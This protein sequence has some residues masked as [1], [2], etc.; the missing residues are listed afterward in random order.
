MRKITY[1]TFFLLNVTLCFSQKQFTLNSFI[2]PMN[3]MVNGIR[4]KVDSVGIKIRTNY[5]KFDVFTFIENEGDM[6]RPII[7]NFKPDSVY[8][9]SYSCCASHDIFS[10]SKLMC[11]SLSLW[12]G[13]ED[14]DK[15]K[16][17]L[18]ERP[19]ISIKTLRNPKDSI[20]AWHADAT[21][22][23]ECKLINTKLW[24]LGI[25][26]KGNYWNNFTTIQFFKTE[27]TIPKHEKTFLEEYLSKDNI[28]ELTTI[29]F[30]LFDNERYLIIYDEKHNTV[31]IK[32]E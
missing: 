23:T 15:V 17:T 31:T 24:P 25:P 20:Y 12:D 5:P 1:L 2:G 10:T 27:T 3:V 28:I 21:C 14:I 13:E 16:N 11:D 18:L 19:F 8:S 9:I 32:Y 26:P 6:N 7:C 4:Y 29:R 22:E 30:L